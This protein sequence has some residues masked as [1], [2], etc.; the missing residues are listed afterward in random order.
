MRIAW[1]SPLPPARSGIATYSADLVQRLAPVHAID[2]FSEANARDFVWRVRR[3]PYDLV[4]YQLGNA[5]CHDYMWAY[6]AAYPGLVVLHDARLHQSRARSL[7]QQGRFDDY[8]REFWYDHPDARRDFAEYAIEGLGGPIYYCWPMLRAVMRTA[9][10]VAVH[11]PRVAAD[12][13]EEFPS[14]AVEAI[15]L[16]TA[17]LDAGAS[18]RGR[19]RA[20]LGVPNDA[21]LFAAFGKITAE[22]RARAILRA[23]EALARERA[24]V[25]LLLA[26]DASDYPALEV[27]RASS[28]HAP[29]VHVSGYVADEAIG[30]YL[31]AS[32]ACL[33]LRWPTALETSASWLQCLAAA[34]PTVL[35]DLAH[36][37]DIPTIEPG[38]RRAAAAGAASMDPVAIA[39]DLLDEDE[40]LLLAMRTL[41]DEPRLREELGRAGHEYWSAHHTLDVMAGDYQRLIAQAVSRPAPIVTDL[42]S[43][44]TENYSDTTRAIAARFGIALDDVLRVER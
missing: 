31:A 17:P 32:D 42:P 39:I 43:H 11:N 25:H 36:L 20:A 37:V 6:L 8:R 4:V 19:V 35:S 9:R 41:A 14:A 40:S 38:G 21:V 3:D 16:G 28:A 27:E 29:R 18:A 10:L 1:F 26:G 22:K 12:L 44:F 23:F 5:P 13:R 30:D 24:D 15:H 7:L 33:C 34:R 2:C